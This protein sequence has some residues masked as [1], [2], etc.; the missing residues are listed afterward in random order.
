MKKLYL[1]FL[2][3]VVLVLKYLKKH[4]FYLIFHASVIKMK[5]FT[6]I[7]HILLQIACRL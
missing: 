3:L 1:Y 6:R 7:R 4:I 5:Y 2:D